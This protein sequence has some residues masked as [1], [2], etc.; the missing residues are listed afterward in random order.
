MGDPRPPFIQDA[1][2]KA[3]NRDSQAALGPGGRAWSRQVTKS[4]RS[5]GSAEPRARGR[6]GEG[7][8]RGGV[9]LAA[10]CKGLP[11]ALEG[12]GGQGAPASGH[13]TPY[14]KMRASCPAWPGR[15]AKA[16]HPERPRSARGRRGRG[17]ARPRRRQAQARPRGAVQ[18]PRASPALRDRPQRVLCP[19]PALPRLSG[20]TRLTTPTVPHASCTQTCHRCS[21][22]T[23]LQIRHPVPYARSPRVPARRLR[24][25]R[26]RLSS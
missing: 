5:S 17:A 2:H 16:P 9:P 10:R 4:E 8:A 13:S 24:H 21:K 19:R 12:T 25:P 23:S 6:P 22:D 15:R 14:S 11:D 3:Q 20:Q 1:S 26:A 7:P 18:L